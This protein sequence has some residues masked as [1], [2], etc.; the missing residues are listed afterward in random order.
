MIW[1]IVVILGAIQ[2]LTEFIPVSS[3]GHLL[4]ADRV[5]GNSNYDGF[6]IGAL[7]NIG[8]LA[9]LVWSCRDRLKRQIDKILKKDF[10]LLGRVLVATVPVG[11]AGFFWLIK[12]N[13]FTTIQL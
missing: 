13:S 3:S 2:G 11:L 9:A 1:L 8:T 12:L 5:F 7:L 6:E 10:R 4:I